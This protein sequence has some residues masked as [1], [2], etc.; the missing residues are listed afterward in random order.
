MPYYV[1]TIWRYNAPAENVPE[2]FDRE[3]IWQRADSP[4]QFA[5]NV[6]ELY[7]DDEVTIGPI[8]HSRFQSFE[9]YLEWRITR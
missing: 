8:S 7:A 9:D 6:R 5:A 3:V 2:F 4:E 1:A